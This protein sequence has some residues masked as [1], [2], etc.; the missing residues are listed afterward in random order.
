MTQPTSDQLMLM[1]ALVGVDDTEAVFSD[2]TFEL[3]FTEASDNVYGGAALAI[4]VLMVNA[5]KRNAY[6]QGQSKEEA[7]QVF[8]NL[9]KLEKKYQKLADEGAVPTG[10]LV[11]GLRSVPPPMYT[12]PGNDYTRYPSYPYGRNYPWRPS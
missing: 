11:V 7:Q 5:A 9:E 10:A 8:E 4:R 12:L 1:Q 3:F 6:T 2:E